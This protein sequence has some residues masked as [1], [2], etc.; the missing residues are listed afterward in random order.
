MGK[1]TREL[2]SK[3]VHLVKVQWSSDPR[4]CTWETEK[5][6]N[7]PTP[8]A[9][10]TSLTNSGARYLYNTLHLHFVSYFTV[11]SFRGRKVLSGGDCNNTEN[12][13]Q[14]KNFKLVISKEFEQLK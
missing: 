12:T 13:S 1:E 9:E 6:L 7:K 3:K 11:V 2:R 14:F 4:D 5:A 8:N 10:W